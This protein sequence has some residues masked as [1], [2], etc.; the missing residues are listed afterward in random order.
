VD[1]SNCGL[2][3]IGEPPCWG[4]GELPLFPQSW[5]RALSKIDIFAHS[6]QLGRVKL[7]G[8]TLVTAKDLCGSAWVK[9]IRKLES[10][11]SDLPLGDLIV[12][13]V[14]DAVVQFADDLDV[15]ITPINSVGISGGTTLPFQ[16]N[17][18][19]AL[20][21]AGLYSDEGITNVLAGTYLELIQKVNDLPVVL[22]FAV[23]A[24]AW[25]HLE[26]L[27]RPFFEIPKF[28]ETLVGTFRAMRFRSVRNVGYSQEAN[29]YTSNFADVLGKRFGLDWQGKWTLD[30]CGQD[31]NLTRERLR[32]I[33]KEAQITFS[34]R[35]WGKSEV[36]N[37]LCGELQKQSG[38]EIFFTEHDGRHLIVDRSAAENLL[39][40]IG[41]DETE[42]QNISASDVQRAE[43]GRSIGDIR[44]EAYQFSGK[45]GFVI[46]ED[47]KAHLLDVYKDWD[48]S[49]FE[50]VKPLI[51][52]KLDLPFG[53]MYVES[54]NKSFFLSWT[55]N[56]FSLQGDLRFDEYYEA[57]A[58]YCVYRLPGVVHPPR[59]VV[60]EWLKTDSRF[61]LNDQDVV[62]IVEAIEVKLG[63]TQQ[64]LRDQ[65]LS[66]TGAVIHRAELMDKAREFGVNSTSI[67]IYCSYER[68][69][70]PV[71]TYCVTLTGMYPSQEFI[72]L[73][74]MRA[75][76]LIVETTI[77]HFEISKDHVIVLLTA[78]SNMCNQGFWSLNKALANAL[79]AK[80]FEL[81]ADD[82]VVGRSSF[83][84]TTTTSWTS[85]LAA[86]GIVP[87]DKLKISFDTKSLVASVDRLDGGPGFED[88]D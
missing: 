40:M 11:E 64:W 78:G 34:P 21:A 12:A 46:E 16:I 2:S 61:I 14:S 30:E 82:H 7:K 52:E 28:E 54:R 65:I 17:T 88:A 37:K 84:G 19:D 25:L 3:L 26:N 62:N 57:S 10:I 69:F 36:M 29:W 81:R 13:F 67:G 24:N 18:C 76:V 20:T 75:N 60:R 58:R 42:Y 22:D 32:Q 35:S 15:P 56:I 73:A 85:A 6:S 80:N 77:D 4:S 31:L 27:R 9:E 44:R 83:F 63:E 33:E 72:D 8:K 38:D 55:Q 68:Y 79:G 39:K 23:T 48:D 53:F 86:L 41:Y 87:G 43:F 47:L 71:D 66:A 51:A 49:K 50:A 45:I 70:K 59:S 5:R 74:Y 1:R